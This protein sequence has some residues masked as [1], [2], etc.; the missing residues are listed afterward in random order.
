MNKKNRL[1]GIIS[2]FLYFFLS[3]FSG[4]IITLIGIDAN[5]LS[6]TGKYI[7][8]LI[9]EL[10][11]LIIIILVQIK[12][13]KV[14]FKDFIFKIKYYLKTYIKYWIFALIFMYAANTILYIIGGDI[15]KNE[16]G[17]RE[18]IKG[19][20]FIMI[21]I[22]CIIGPITEE[23]IFRVS[24]YKILG[25]YKWL[26]I[27]LSGFIFGSM[28]VLGDAKTL[29]DYLYIIPYGIPGSFFAYTL[30][31]SKNSCVPISLHI[32]HNTFAIILQFI[33]M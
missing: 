16:Q 28:H 32:I 10:F 33:A 12:S 9:Y 7:L 29:I 6:N 4:V 20:E 30:Y 15:A 17:V 26:F 18:L 25:K 19:N 1:L 22:A 5:N 14:D 21:I 23:L 2:I 13:L 27:I 11:V 8:S 3:I 24:L 31:E